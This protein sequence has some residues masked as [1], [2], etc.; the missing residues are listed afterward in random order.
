MFANFEGNLFLPRLLT[1]AVFWDS[2]CFNRLVIKVVVSCYF[3]L[4]PQRVAHLR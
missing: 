2:D 1:K 3:S 4:P